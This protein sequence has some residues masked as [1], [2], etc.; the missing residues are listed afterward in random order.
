MRTSKFLFFSRNFSMLSAC[1]VQTILIWEPWCYPLGPI[2]NVL[3]QSF[4]TRLVRPLSPWTSKHDRCWLCIFCVRHLTRPGV[5]FGLLDSFLP[6]HFRWTTG[7]SVTWIQ[8][9]Q[10]PVTSMEGYAVPEE[11]KGKRSESTVEGAPSII[12][13]V[14][15]RFKYGRSGELRCGQ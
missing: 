6:G 12:R 4:V 3:L 2:S 8:K 15:A 10:I 7:V 1:C 13:R 11:D 14:G 9:F 5:C